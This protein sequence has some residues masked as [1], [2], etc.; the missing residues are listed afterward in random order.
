MVSPTLALDFIWKLFEKLLTLTKR[1]RAPIRSEVSSFRY[2]DLSDTIVIALHP[3]RY[4]AKLALTNR[5]DRLVYI[6]TLSVTIG[7]EHTY[8]ERTL[9]T[10][11]RRLEPHEL[12]ELDVT[13]PVVGDEEPVEL[14]TFQLDII[15]TVGRRTTI[16]GSFPIEQSEV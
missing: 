7:E 13:F 2:E 3:R 6:K 5:S 12:G 1:L 9:G 4:R 15:P 14:G 10:A 8:R 11:V 16:R